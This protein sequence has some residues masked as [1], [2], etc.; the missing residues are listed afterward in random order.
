MKDL[1]I[2]LLEASL[3][4]ALVIN[5]FRSEHLTNQSIIFFAAIL[6]VAFILFSIIPIKSKLIK[7]VHFL[8][9]ILILVVTNSSILFQKINERKNMKASVHDGVIITEAAYKALISGKNPY[10]V[11]FSEELSSQKYKGK[12]PNHAE[13]RYPYSPIL[14]FMNV[15]ILLLSQSFGTVDMRI[16]LTVFF[17]LT[18]AVGAY[19][20][21]QKRLFLIIFLTNPLF[22]PLLFYGAN[23]ILVLFWLFLCLAFLKMGRNTIAT[24]MLA[25]AFGTKLLIFPFIPFYFLCLYFFAKSSSKF[26]IIIGQIG[27][28]I[29]ISLAIYG[30]FLIWNAQDLTNDLLVSWIKGDDLGHSIVG[31]IGLPQILMKLGL[32]GINSKFPFYIFIVPVSILYIIFSYKLL[33]KFRNL[34]VLLSLLVIYFLLVFSFSRIIQTY[35]LA[36]VSQIMLLSAFS[37]ERE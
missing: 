7:N 29:L 2:Y 10:S 13:E 8:V 26:K 34:S 21:S 37:K 9:L 6:F 30:P 33:D 17:F 14:I 12:I 11:N 24:I 36:F 20:V 25:L 15:P 23:E 1:N 35:Y 27:V 16:T 4:F 32:V 3:L 31:F 28:F 22:V 5:I 19:Y 18:A